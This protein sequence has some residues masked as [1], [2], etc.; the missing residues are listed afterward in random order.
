MEMT[1]TRLTKHNKCKQK[2]IL[3]PHGIH[4]A[5]LICKK[6]QTHIQWLS[7]AQYK[8]IIQLFP[9]TVEFDGVKER[10]NR[11]KPAKRELKFQR[12]YGNNW[13]TEYSYSQ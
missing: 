9:E 8:A 6:H 2:A 13:N 7:K 10:P 5:R 11:Q 4:Y 12:K 3:G 1:I